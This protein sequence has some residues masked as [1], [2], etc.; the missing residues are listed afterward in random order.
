MN[1]KFD[2]IYYL[3]RKIFGNIDY[4]FGNLAL[5]FTEMS[6]PPRLHFCYVLATV[7]MPM[8][9]TLPWKRYSWHISVNRGYCLRIMS[10]NTTVFVYFSELCVTTSKK[11]VR[12]SF[13]NL[14]FLCKA[15]KMFYEQIN[16]KRSRV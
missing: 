10:V 8:L 6:K 13:C 7:V 5:N 4:P 1:Q 14:K 12:S 16:M 11:S 2:L 15:N 9:G 3:C